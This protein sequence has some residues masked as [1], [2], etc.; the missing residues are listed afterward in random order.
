MAGTK[1]A[2]VGGSRGKEH[3]SE[4]ARH[5]HDERRVHVRHAPRDSSHLTGTLSEVQHGSGTK[6]RSAKDQATLKLGADSVDPLGGE[7]R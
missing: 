4:S 1:N 5:E 6:G 7:R 2:E 3:R